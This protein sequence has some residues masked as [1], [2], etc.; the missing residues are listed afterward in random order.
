MSPSL[1]GCRGTDC[2]AHDGKLLLSAAVGHFKESFAPGKI[3]KF[4]LLFQKVDLAVPV[5]MDIS[6]LRQSFFSCIWSL[7]Y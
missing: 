4:I 7:S 2:V 1:R 5:N 3:R 6:D